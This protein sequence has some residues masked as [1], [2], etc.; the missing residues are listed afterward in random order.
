MDA[1]RPAL[2][3]FLT[4][5]AT[6][7]ADGELL[8]RRLR[9]A[10]DAATATPEEMDTLIDAFTRE[11]TRT[12]QTRLLTPLYPFGVIGLLG[13]ARDRLRYEHL[14]NSGACNCELVHREGLTSQLD[15]RPLVRVGGSSEDIFD[16]YEDFEC[17]SCHT[18]WRHQDCSTE[19]YTSWAWH[20]LRAPPP[21]TS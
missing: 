17:L 19:Q 9:E 8:L 10:L 4:T 21:E 2:M 14:S 15:A 1:L 3:A 18:V 13:A 16:T 20:L 6:S 5:R 12:G 11:A 7:L